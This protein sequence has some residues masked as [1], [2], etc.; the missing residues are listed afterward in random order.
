[1]KKIFI[2][3]FLLACS[4]EKSDDEI[5]SSM[6]SPVVIIGIKCKDG[7]YSVVSLKGSDDKIVTIHGNL[8]ATLCD[9]KIGDKI[10]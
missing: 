8:A 7:W 10:K 1:M 4:R 9:R 2:L 3:F 6:K 5:I